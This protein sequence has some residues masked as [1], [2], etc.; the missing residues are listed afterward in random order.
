MRASRVGAA[1][2]QVREER[3][4]AARRVVNIA[5]EKNCDFLLVAGDTFEDNAVQRTKVQRIGDILAGF[6]GPV[7]II[8]GNH[9]P[10]VP[11]SVWEHAVW[12]T[13]NLH[14][15]T[16]AA[17]LEIPGGTLFPCPL[18]E[19]HSTADP[20]L[21]INANDRTEICIGLGHGSVEGVQMEEP[22]Y[23]IARNAAERAGLD[24][25]GIGHWHSYATYSTN[26]EPARLVYS[27]TH[28]TTKFGERNSGNAVLVEIAERGAAPKLTS[29]QTGGLQWIV[30]EKEISE[31]AQLTELLSELEALSDPQ[32]T[33][34]S[35]RLSGLLPGEGNE[36][37]MRLKELAS[38]EAGRF[39]FAEVIDRL[40]PAP[41]DDSWIDNAPPGLMRNVLERLRLYA[42]GGGED[43][44]DYATPEV[45]ARAIA[46]LY[47]LI[48]QSGNNE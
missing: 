34:L 20:T 48:S 5:N 33:L 38:P 47:Q 6:N 23:P 24:Y 25:L 19:K 22:D 8:S 46:E 42:S 28:E 7:Y 29:I 3:V 18:F 37:L 1:G 15:I 43:R 27:G 40:L 13:E 17:P 44:P 9:D 36:A 14:V 30:W 31:A 35:I 2:D 26:G 39:L 32:D 21:W 11:G 10:L 12:R 16:E 4:E 45:S 41:D